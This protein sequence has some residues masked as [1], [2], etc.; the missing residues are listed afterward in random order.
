VPID[1]RR[2]GSNGQLPHVGAEL[3][4]SFVDGAASA[5]E[6]EG[7]LRHI[8]SCADCRETLSD[9]ALAVAEEKRVRPGGLTQPRPFPHRRWIL[10][11][12]GGLAAAA[13]VV[14][15]VWP[16]P[17][18]SGASGPDLQELIAAV[19]AQ[20]ARPVE[21]RL[22]GG[23]PYAPPPAVVRGGDLTTAPPD[24]RIAA[25]RLE[26]AS[27]NSTAAVPLW[28]AGIARLATGD[29][30][31]A[32]ATLEEAARRDARN[33]LIHSD[34]A[35]AYL[36]RGRANSSESDVES[37]LR[38][39][40]RALELAPGRPEALFNRALALDMMRAPGARD[41]WEDVVRVEPGSPWAA[42]ASRRA[43]PAARP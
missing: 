41:A 35:G 29:F 22:T 12:A 28:G 9:L 32:V 43:S 16:G 23:F 17:T 1:D 40:D 2:A 13:V 30:D 38:A 39:A 31:G 4:A 15:A 18:R 11:A 3:M 24:V 27:L 37:A 7:V 5:T 34:L 25:G 19:G 20:P 26:S 14:L 42:E 10:G 21:A 6:R 33:G 36:A 8:A